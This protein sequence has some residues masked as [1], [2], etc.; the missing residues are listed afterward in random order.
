MCP[1]RIVLADPT[2]LSAR[3]FAFALESR[4]HEVVLAGSAADV[5]GA[6]GARV[7]GIVIDSD[8][9]DMAVDDLCQALRG[10]TY[11]GP[12]LVVSDAT[13]TRAKLCAFGSGADDYVVRPCDPVEVAARMEVLARR[14]AG[15]EASMLADVLTVADVSL[16]L[17]SLTVRRAGQAARPLAPTEMR[18][19]AALMESSPAPMSREALADRVWGRRTEWVGNQVEVY[20]RRLRK[21]LERDPGQPE[22]IHTIR[23]E[24]YAFRPRGARGAPGRD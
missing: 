8:L 9:P 3:V 11:L 20:I 5:L 19:L 18:L 21:Q 13:A 1:V 17:T 7:D 22:Y 23:G 2:T 10:A 4:G 6:A 15:S 24:G 16:S 12:I 14:R